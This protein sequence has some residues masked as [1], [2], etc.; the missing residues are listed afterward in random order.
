MFTNRFLSS[1]I[2]GLPSIAYVTLHFQTN[3]AQI[4]ASRAVDRNE[5]LGS[6]RDFQNFVETN[7]AHN[8]LREISRKKIQATRAPRP[9]Q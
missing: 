5:F 9:I 1:C 6:I 3:V 4:C 7:K 2:K 8:R